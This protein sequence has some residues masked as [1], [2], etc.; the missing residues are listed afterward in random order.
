MEIKLNA[1]KLKWQ[2]STKEIIKNIFDFN[3]GS[4]ITDIVDIEKDEESIAFLLLFNTTRKTIY[5]LLTKYLKQELSKIENLGVKNRL[6]EQE[7][8]EFFESEITITKDFFYNVIQYNPKYLTKSFRIF[9]KYADEL[10]LKLS[11]DIHYDYY[12]LFRVILNNE[13]QGDKDKYSK[14]IQYFDNPIYEETLKQTFLFDHYKIIASY[15]TSRLQPE[16]EAAKE[17][18]QDLYIE[19]N[20]TVFRKNIIKDIPQNYNFESIGENNIHKFINDYFFKNLK[21]PELKSNYKMLFLL[22]QPGQ[23]KTSFSYKVVSDYITSSFGLPE[24][25]IFFVKIRDL[26]AKDFINSPFEVL[27]K[28]FSS[29]F[30][31]EKEKGILILDG[32]DEAYMSGGIS[33]NDLRNLY[34]RLNKDGSENLKIILT[35]RKNYVN[36]NDACVDNSLVIEL[37]NFTNKQV[38]DYKNKFLKF[39]PNNQFIKKLDA[40]INEDKKN[41][42]KHIQELIRQPVI[43]YF[44]ALANIDVER[45]NSKAAI[46]SKIF[47]SLSE[48]SWDKR[49]GQLDFVNKT[50]PK[51]KYQ[52]LLRDFI[53][54]IA[55]E[56]YQSPNLYITVSKLS[57]LEATK[58]FV[59]KC[60]EESFVSNEDNFKKV[61]KY[62]L[63]SFYFQESKNSIV[64]TAIEFFHNSLWEYLTAEYIWEKFKDLFLTKDRYDEYVTIDIKEYFHLLDKIIGIKELS[65]QVKINL[66]DIILSEDAFVLRDLKR[67]ANKLFYRLSDCDFLLFYNNEINVL[68]SNTKAVEIFELSFTIHNTL[69]IALKELTEV[70]EN[71]VKFF[72]LNNFRYHHIGGE[73]Q[74]ISALAQI[75]LP[76]GFSVDISNCLFEDL[77]NQEFSNFSFNNIIFRKGQFRNCYFDECNFLNTYFVEMIIIKTTFIKNNFMDSKFHNVSFLSVDTYKIFRDSNYFNYDFENVHV[78]EENDE[79]GCEI[80]LKDFSFETIKQGFYK[81]LKYSNSIPQHRMV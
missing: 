81:R 24:I 53:R 80:K 39:Y 12:E 35:S 79:G 52:Y 34:D 23:G 14:L 72:A 59:K 41:K 46:Y 60:F 32:L 76:N 62:L 61:T 55:F 28:K 65:Y 67:Q 22:G 15:Y 56:I 58:I 5:E 20:F 4:V 37:A 30:N 25:P 33:D 51:Q 75:F 69:D 19:P 50:L 7:I 54:N 1:S 42:Y 13:F 57:S 10:D 36:L 71:F 43:V 49:K 31:F 26:V 64:E 48:R 8:K 73:I 3:W 6:L 70:N 45:L 16:V 17:T 29:N 78:I 77:F 18:L 9:K 2:V 27:F 21:H 63:I 40:I 38:I 47:S 66:I 44:I 11:S 68:S 74:N